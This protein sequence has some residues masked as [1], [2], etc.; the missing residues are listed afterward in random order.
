M[1]LTSLSTS[2]AV[3][4]FYDMDTNWIPHATIKR[5]LTD[6]HI[7]DRILGVSEKAQLLA[8]S[9]AKAIIC[10]QHTMFGQQR[11]QVFMLNIRKN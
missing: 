6:G 8:Y 9:P 2:P 10:R 5:M 3:I 7:T 1:I 4:E 11:E